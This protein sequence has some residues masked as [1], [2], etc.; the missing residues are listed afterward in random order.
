MLNTGN[1]AALKII[2]KWLWIV[3]AGTILIFLALTLFNVMGWLRFSIYSAIVVGLSYNF[4]RTASKE[5][6]AVDEN[7]SDEEFAE[8]SEEDEDTGSPRSFIKWLIIVAIIAAVFIVL[9]IIYFASSV[10]TANLSLPE[11]NFLSEIPG[12]VW[13]LIVTIILVWIIW[14]FFLKGKSMPSLPSVKNFPSL[15]WG[16][17]LLAATFVALGYGAEI[18][19]KVSDEWHNDHHHGLGT[20]SKTP[21]MIAKLNGYNDPWPNAKEVTEP[22]QYQL[23][24]GVIYKYQGKHFTMTFVGDRNGVVITPLDTLNGYGLFMASKDCLVK[25]SDHP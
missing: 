15:A 25:T 6:S 20:I 4:Q 11:S 5:P 2:F 22:G 12:W 21:A 1:E 13:I 18:W 9:P 8:E 7:L 10:S 16:L 19:E 24:S 17:L 14:R 3:C 23:T